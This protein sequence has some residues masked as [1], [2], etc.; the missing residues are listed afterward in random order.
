MKIAILRYGAMALLLAS[1]NACHKV[2]EPSVTNHAKSEVKE[3][4]GLSF[5]VSLNDVVDDFRL[6]AYDIN[7]ENGM[8]SLNFQLIMDWSKTEEGRQKLQ[9]LNVSD[10]Q[11]PKVPMHLFFKNANTGQ[12]LYTLV[13]M[14]ITGAKSLH[15]TLKDVPLLNALYTEESK[16]AWYI[17]AF[18]GGVKE[19]GNSIIYCNDY[20]YDIT[21]ETS[22]Y[23]TYSNEGL[24]NPYTHVS[25]PFP[26]ESAWQKLSKTQGQS[27]SL[28]PIG[29]VMRLKVSN[30]SG[31]MIKASS[32]DFSPKEAF[33]AEDIWTSNF[34]LGDQDMLVNNITRSI[35]S[36]TPNPQADI[37]SS[38]QTQ[39]NSD[40]R[41][42]YH[43]MKNTSEPK[44]LTIPQGKVRFYLFWVMTNESALAT[45]FETIPVL[46]SVEVRKTTRPTLPELKRNKFGS[47]PWYAL[48]SLSKG[49]KIPRTKIQS[50]TSYLIQT[51]IR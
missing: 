15:T 7:N 20:L 10:G 25:L 19:E 16:D 30:H 3:A 42:H 27:L 35:E 51:T 28:K 49:I 18:L 33:V 2:D 41:V 40:G 36:T 13:S 29:T 23:I 22:M 43:A 1:L 39:Y 46:H 32:L 14:D 37:L 47:A 12:T 8:P 44:I 38:A 17:K 4:V 5:D 9:E 50:G 24:R 45:N 6:A 11:A 34:V 21:D 48:G 31:K 26:M